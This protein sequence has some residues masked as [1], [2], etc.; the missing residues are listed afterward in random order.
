MDAFLEADVIL[1]PVAP[2]TAFK[3]NELIEDPIVMYQ[4]DVYTTPAS[5]A[6]LPALSLPCGFSGQMPVG[7]QLIGPHFGEASL[8][9]LA[10]NIKMKPTG[11]TPS[12]VRR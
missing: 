8:L 10:A 2:S 6:G 1:T 3:R 9:N 4:Q 11:T 12:G 7:M 5:L